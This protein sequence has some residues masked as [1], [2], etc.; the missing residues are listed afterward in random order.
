[1]L[2]A[3]KMKKNQRNAREPK[4][5][6][7]DLLPDEMVVHVLCFV[8]V[9]SLLDCRLVCRRWR[10][11]IDSRVYQEKAA[12]ENEFVNNGRGFYSF[13]QIDSNTVRKLNLPW[14]VFYTVCKHDPFNRNLVKNHCGQS[15]FD[16]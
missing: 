7:F 16:R 14:Y 12:Q 1:M 11:F 3:L 5:N 4:K 10:V 15:K 8:P 13:S 9:D 2:K 6:P